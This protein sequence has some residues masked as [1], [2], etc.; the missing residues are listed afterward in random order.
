MISPTHLFV[1][2]SLRRGAGHLMHGMLAEYGE[3]VGAAKLP[4]RLY[5][6]AG[7]PGAVASGDPQDR[8]LGEVYLLREPQ[9]ILPLLDEYEGFGADC[10]QPNEFVR[11]AAEVELAGAEMLRAWVYMYNRPIE[12]LALIASGDFLARG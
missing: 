6:I 11:I 10:P 12:R 9:I 2:G 8:V 4:G 7:Y 5:R 1:Y 3:Y